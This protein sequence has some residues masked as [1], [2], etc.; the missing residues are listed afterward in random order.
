[1][2]C[3]DRLGE[4]KN[5]VCVMALKPVKLLLIKLVCKFKIAAS[6]KVKNLALSEAVEIF[7]TDCIVKPLAVIALVKAWLLSA[8]AIYQ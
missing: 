7:K 1:M 3:G 2:T 8:C 4:L 5:V 6:S